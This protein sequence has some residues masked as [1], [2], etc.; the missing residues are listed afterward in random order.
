[1]IVT[2][3]EQYVM[4]VMAMLP[5]LNIVQVSQGLVKARV[6]CVV[7]PP[8]RL[9]YLQKQLLAEQEERL[10]IIDECNIT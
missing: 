3:L 8:S 6:C 5:D 10:T 2:T 7:W 4:N 1:M 9:Q